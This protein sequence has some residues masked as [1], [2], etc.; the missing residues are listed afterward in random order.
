MKE[1]NMAKYS[2]VLDVNL[3]QLKEKLAEGETFDQWVA[4]NLFRCLADKLEECGIEGGVGFQHYVHFCVE[5]R[6]VD[7]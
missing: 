2:L 1:V 6:P 7:E 5:K 4:S 3:D